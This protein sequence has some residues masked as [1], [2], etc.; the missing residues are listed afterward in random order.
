MTLPRPVYH[1]WGYDYWQQLP[2]GRVAAG[3]C[4]DL[5]MDAEWT[6]DAT[7]TAAIQEAI[8]A[9][10]RDRVGA[11]APITH[12]WAALV[13]Y[14]DD[15][16]PVLEPVRDGV[17]VAGAYSGTGN[18]LSSLCARAAVRALLGENPEPVPLLARA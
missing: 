3:G 1:R 17:W 12:R 5:A 4:R 11:R 6:Y 15:E 7:P 10:L 14:S 13:S 2:D 18:V 16:L 8:T 9:L